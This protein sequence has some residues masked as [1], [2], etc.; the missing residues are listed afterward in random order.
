MVRKITPTS[1]GWR[2]SFGSAD[3]QRAFEQSATRTLLAFRPSAAAWRERAIQALSA[4]FIGRLHAPA[5]LA[6]FRTFAEAVVA[7][8]VPVLP[9][10]TTTPREPLEAVEQRRELRALLTYATHADQ[11]FNEWIDAIAHLLDLII[12]HIPEHA[13]GLATSSLSVPL[14]DVVA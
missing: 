2:K 3:Q 4:P 11:F 8:E 1:G 12:D 9:E 7:C 10:A 6:A 13:T 14:I 5:L